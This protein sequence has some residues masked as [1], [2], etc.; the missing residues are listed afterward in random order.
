MFALSTGDH[1]DRPYKSMKSNPLIIA[2]DTPSRLKALNLVHKLKVTGCAFK[3]GFE[4]FS[5]AGPRFVE[6]LVNHDVRIFLDLKFHDIPNTVARAAETATKMG[7]WMFNVHAFGGSEMMRRTVDAVKTVVARKKI[8]PPLV[9]GVTV[10][11]SFSDLHEINVP[12]SV[13]DQVI[14]L[15]SLSQK[16]GLDGV[17]ASGLEAAAIRKKMGKDFC[18][19][20]PGIRLPG[21]PPDDQ[22]RTLTPAEAL[23]N[24]SDYLVIGRPVIEALRPLKV[25]E[26]IL[27]KIR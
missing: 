18:I 22:K 27:S 7:V 12:L 4:L 8:P 9:V 15:A 10:L 26:S 3:I 20:T 11:T 5:S 16:S 13:D 24:G 21:S 14:S 1:K 2:L 19:V 6:R 25:M 17:V 23:K